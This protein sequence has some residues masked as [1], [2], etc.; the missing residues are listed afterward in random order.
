MDDPIFQPYLPTIRHFAQNRLIIRPSKDEDYESLVD[1]ELAIFKE[2]APGLFRW[3]NENPGAFKSEFYGLEKQNPEKRIFYTI[4]TPE[5]EIAGSGGLLRHDP[6]KKPDVAEIS[7]IYLLKEY[8]GR[9]LGKTLV[10]DLIKKAEKLDYES[11]YL[12]TRKEFCAAVSLYKKL[13]FEKAK[14]QKYRGKNSVS[15]ELKL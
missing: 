11:V 12:T 6:E 10:L 1:M 4:E 7:S 5:K 8:R 9:K 15:L 3:Y 14:K 2:L 13:G